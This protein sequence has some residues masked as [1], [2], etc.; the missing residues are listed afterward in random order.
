[1]SEYLLKIKARIDALI[2]IGYDASGEHMDTILDGLSG[3]Y[4]AF[5]TSVSNRVEPFTVSE[6]EALLLSQEACVERNKLKVLSM[7]SLSV[8]LA[9]T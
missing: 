8:N 5:V 7:E 4:D 6:I 2:A 9:S 1:M 3:D